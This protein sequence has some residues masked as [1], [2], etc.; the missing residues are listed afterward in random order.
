MNLGPAV[1]I[2]GVRFFDHVPACISHFENGHWTKKAL[3]LIQS[4][5]THLVYAL[6]KTSLILRRIDMKMDPFTHTN[7]RLLFKKRLVV[8][9]HGLNNNPS[10]FKKILDEMQKEDL[11]ETDIL[12]PRVLQRGNATLDEMVQ[13]IFEEI[14][15]WARTPG[16]KELVLIGISNGGRISRAIEAEI[17]KSEENENI[18]K[19]RFISIVG[20][21]RGS[22][23]VDLA[24]KLGLSWL[25]SKNISTEMPTASERNRRL[26]Q[27]WMEGLSKGPIREYTFFASPH[28]WQVTN[29]DSSLMEVY[30]QQARYAIVSG[31]G[32]NSI[33][34]AVA[35]SV[36]KIILA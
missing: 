13:P 22:S 4:L 20:A 9:V 17:A 16:E 27:E 6:Y 35:K 19:L 5:G 36:A 34:D 12:I 3:S 29:Y 30:G 1:E 21:C 14:E 32:H 33:V 31:H 8:C 18:K 10:Q 2:Q 24:N 11:S 25:M 28:D 23:L 26:N 15:R 7:D